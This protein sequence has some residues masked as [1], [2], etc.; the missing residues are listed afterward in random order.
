VRYGGT[1][2]FIAQ[3]A[4]GL[5][6]SGHHVIVYANG[7]SHVKGELRFMYPRSEWPV[8][9]AAEAAIKELAHTAWACE[10]AARSADIVHVNC[11]P[12]VVFSR[13]VSTPFVATLHHPAEPALSELYARHPEVHYVAISR[14]QQ[15]RERLPQITTVHH[16]IDLAR[17]RFVERKEPYL[18]FLG[19]IA[20]SKAPHLAIEV[21]RRAGLPLKLAG[22]IQPCFE[23]YW[24]TEVEPLV[25]GKQ[26]EYLGEADLEAKNELLGHASA[27]LFPIEWNEPFGLVMIEA[28]A[29]GTPVLAFDAGSVSEVVLDG[30]SGWICRDVDDMARRAR[31]LDIDAGDC[32]A[33][34]AGHFTIAQ[35][36]RGYE[37][38]YRRAIEA[39]RA[40]LTPARFVAELDLSHAPSRHAAAAPPPASSPASPQG[41]V[42]GGQ[43]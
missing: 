17:Y 23:H 16:G 42:P 30:V 40:P 38:V 33:H 10:D 18:A 6:K 39:E 25:D 41:A 7:E 26:V 21:A 32:R 20:P 22:E 28:M 36:T 8:P 24:E 35:M 43:S 5:T 3:L 1:E 4:S 14:A 9:S 15:A 34:V 12:G 13:Y 31:T 37:E 27:L 11:G 2:L 29:C 19:R